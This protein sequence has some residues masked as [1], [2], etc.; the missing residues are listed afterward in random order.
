[1]YGSNFGAFGMQRPMF[2]SQFYGQQPQQEQYQGKGKGRVQELTDTDWEKQFEELTT[3]DNEA[4]LDQLDEQA[5]RDIEEALN[6]V[7]RSETNYGDFESIWQGIQAETNASRDMF[8]D[9]DLA[10]HLG[11]EYEQWKDFDGMNQSF[12][13]LR[14]YD[15]R[16]EFA[17]YIF[18]ENNLFQDVPN[19]FEE[20]QKIMREG[21]NLSLAALA[22]EAAVQKEPEFIEAWVA[23]GTAQAQNEKETPA[24]RAMERA[25]KLDPNNLEALMG[26]SVSY[27]NE[28]YDSLAYRTLERWISV[29]YPQLGVAPRKLEEAA[30]EDMGF[31]DRHMLHEKVTGMFLEAAQLNPEGS[32]VDVD[33]QVGLGVLFYGSEDYEKAVDCFQAALDSH[34]HGALKREGEEHLLWNRLGATLANSNHSEQAIDAYERALELRPNFVRARYNLGVSCINLGVFEQA[35]G[36]LLGALSMHRVMESEGRQKAAELLRDGNGNAVD[37]SVVDGLLQQNQS[38]NLYDTLRRVFREMSRRDLAEMVGPDM[39][40]DALRGEFD[41]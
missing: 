35:A 9:E 14:T 8:A 39:N 30:E 23:L 38:T 16:P 2:Q 5:N 17:N 26:L 31:T 36:H 34:Q 1:M 18:E 40:L 29:K 33:V 32:E 22:F 25:L 21:G 7:D 4:Q 27:T 3:A 11:D 13:G 41:F 10:A 19:A 15:A 24:I 37:D 28:G 20:G 6:G 12:D